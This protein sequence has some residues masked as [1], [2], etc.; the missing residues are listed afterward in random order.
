[1]N[2]WEEDWS[3]TKV[4]TTAPVAPTRAPWEEDWSKTRIVETAPVTP[5]P[6][7]PPEPAIEPKPATVVQPPAITE[8][9]A[10][11]S[12]QGLPGQM[13][14]GGA[15]AVKNIGRSAAVPFKAGLA[16]TGGIIQSQ[17]EHPII[18]GAITGGVP[19]AAAGVVQAMLPEE[20]WGKAVEFG[21]TVSDYWNQSAAETEAQIPE[22][23]KGALTWEKAKRPTYWANKVGGLIGSFAPVLTGPAAPYVF[24]AQA[25][26]NTYDKLRKEGL[27]ENDA[28]LRS[29]VIG[30]INVGLMKFGLD[31]VFKGARQTALA[32]AVTS[33]LT[34]MAVMPSLS[35]SQ[36]LS[37]ELNREGITLGW[38]VQ[39]ALVAAGE[40]LK[41]PAT[42]ILATAGA[43]GAAARKPARPDLA[44]PTPG[45]AGSQAGGPPVSP[46]TK[47]RTPPELPATGQP[48]EPAGAKP[49]LIPAESVKQPIEPVPGETTPRVEIKPGDIVQIEGMPGKTFEVQDILEV[50]PD[51]Q[52]AGTQLYHLH[53]PATDQIITV[54]GKQIG[55]IKNAEGIRGDQG[56]LPGERLQTETS[57]GNRGENLQQPTQGQESLEQGKQTVIPS[58]AIRETLIAVSQDKTQKIPLR[59][60]ARALT[61]A[62]DA[63]RIDETEAQKRWDKAIGNIKPST[64]TVPSGSPPVETSGT[65][66]TPGESSIPESPI[67]PLSPPPIVPAT[68]QPEKEILAP[69]RESFG[70]AETGADVQTA[71]KKIGRAGSVPAPS[72]GFWQDFWAKVKYLFDPDR[73]IGRNMYEAFNQYQRS[74]EAANLLG[75]EYR[76]QIRRIVDGLQKTY[77]RDVVMEK[78]RQV[79]DGE[80]TVDQFMAEF[81]LSSDSSAVRG[82]RTIETANRKREAFIAEWEGLPETLQQ[83]IRD[84]ANY[85]T[86]AYLRFALGDKY[87]P[88]P[89][90]YQDAIHDVRAGIEAAVEKMVRQATWL[91]SRQT[92][93]YFNVPVWMETGDP[94]LIAG[95]SE[96]RRHAANLLREKYLEL[97]RVIDAVGYKDGAVVADL[98]ASALHGA[99]EDWVNYYL[100]RKTTTG[101]GATGGIEIGRLQYRF[102]EGA[103]RKLYGEITDPAERQALTATGQAHIL[104]GMTLF[105]RIFAE[106]E[107][108][109]WAHT[110]E[111]AAR[112][113]ERLGDVNNP[114]DRKRFGNL[115]GKYVTPEFYHMVQGEKQ[116]GSIAATIKAAWYTPMSVQRI[117][118]LLTPKTMARNYLTAISGFALGSGDVFYPTWWRRFAEGHKILWRFAKGDPDA[119]AIVREMHE[120]GAF[121]SSATSTVED[122]RQALGGA[123]EKM[124]GAGEKIIEA[125]TYIDFPTKYASF[126]AT[127]DSGMTPEAAAQHVREL[128]QD[129]SRTPRIVGKFSR[130]GFADYISYSYD[131][132]RIA[133]NQVL[134]AVN[135]L[136]RGD[137]RAAMGLFLSR[138]IWATALMQGSSALL[139][140]VKALAKLGGDEDKKEGVYEAANDDELSALRNLVPQYD[141]N[142]PLLL[143]RRKHPDGT[144]T[145]HYVVIGGQT[146]F[147]LE[148][149]II[150]ALQSRA[151]GSSFL[152]AFGQ[153]VLN[154]VDPGMQIGAIMRAA[155]GEDLQGKATPTGKGLID[156]YPGK[157]EP[158]RARII[159]DVA[160]GLAM[161][162]LPEYPVKMFRD[163]WQRQVKEDAGVHQV[164]MLA[165]HEREAS[166]ILTSAHRLIRG[167][168]IEQTDANAMLI[169]VIRPYVTALRET[170]TIISQ[171]ARAG[172]EKGGT[173]PD[174]KARAESAQNA[175]ADY[176]RVIGERV[177][178]AQIFAPDWFDT[179]KTF[180]VLTL[181]GMSYANIIPVLQLAKG[182]MKQPQRKVPAPRPNA[183]RM[184][185]AP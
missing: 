77:G 157:V 174:D 142:M 116:I 76:N 141:R 143:M 64:E 124:T 153:S 60:K 66:K 45:Q 1:M 10:G 5:P 131:S 4:V 128:Y 98:N 39:D 99:A 183:L 82:L 95:L 107:G 92:R 140:V 30:A 103:F 20:I 32:R 18:S 146:A 2:P 25:Y 138:A 182:E 160:I 74:I 14:E 166:D 22:L 55:G 84:N 40:S 28:A 125:Y 17:A 180:S 61:S 90:A 70:L 154:A 176:L 167:Y 47:T 57:E 23:D 111:S 44:A 156:A 91:V 151:R 11:R 171:T 24:G 3:K 179:G 119:I 185:P 36:V 7:P 127:Q 159:R 19:G 67:S 8:P 178:D 137:P 147:P 16:A 150:G 63:G 168:R 75:K 83:T 136:R 49:P 112:L 108:M 65:I 105:R 35:A 51:E 69:I 121:S 172:I 129:R 135:E 41:D 71:A 122:L 97:R 72:I 88:T 38:T 46:G 54:E 79:Q 21:K 6:T 12:Y 100:N 9:V 110:P 48:G 145:R 162:Y 130:T 89:Q 144:I 15:E 139:G 93:A 148:D 126:M 27:S 152:D 155:T 177:R 164:G 29:G 26:G 165:R 80:M 78:L 123:P 106:G 37:E 120:K 102:M 149:A 52:K 163:L 104:A 114:M 173:L 34:T 13:P 96:T 58:P 85:Q 161:D 42:W 175:R 134:H 43:A 73:G 87:E 56:Q 117:A 132:G 101:G 170:E 181:S 59:Q 62:L 50:T 118:K 86:R 133:V 53:D 81:R 94:K 109:L 169:K 113:T 115:A 31:K 158:D 33:Y 68:K 184:L